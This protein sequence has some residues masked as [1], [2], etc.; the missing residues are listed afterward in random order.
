[1]YE[2]N[3]E[4]EFSAAHFLKLYDG[5]WEPR[6]GHRF[7]VTVTMSSKRL[8][9]IGVVA[10]FEWLRPALKKT[11]A[12][13]HE[14]SLNDHPDFKNPHL[15]TSVENIARIIYDRLAPAVPVGHARITRVTVWETPDANASYCPEEK[16]LVR[17]KK[18]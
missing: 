14:K 4:D 17:R 15:N 13:F 18:K 8:D 12:E 3:L 6:H 2:I 5:S 10:D 7:K 9:R 16:G 1:V 11:L